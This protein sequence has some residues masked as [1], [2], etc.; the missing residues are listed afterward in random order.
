VGNWTGTTIG[1]AS[2]ALVVVVGGGDCPASATTIV[3]TTTL[4]TAA[5]STRRRS[6]CRT[7]SGAAFNCCRFPFRRRP[8]RKLLNHD[9]RIVANSNEK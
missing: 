7:R 1:G 9:S 3:L 8:A 4:E 2:V 6:N 5:S